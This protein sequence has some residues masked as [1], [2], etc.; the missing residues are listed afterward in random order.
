MAA[1]VFALDKLPFNFAVHLTAVMHVSCC[2]MSSQ[3]RTATDLPAAVH[4]PD[5]D[6]LRIS[7]SVSMEGHA[8]LLLETNPIP[9]CEPAFAA[10]AAAAPTTPGDELDR[11]RHVQDNLDKSLS[12]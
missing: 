7:S 12:F 8:N 9:P 5:S 4:D 6:K 11:A 1:Q 3:L 2:G 10:A